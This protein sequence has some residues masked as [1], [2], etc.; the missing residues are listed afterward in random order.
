[1]SKYLYPVSVMWIAWSEKYRI[2]VIRDHRRNIIEPFLEYILAKARE[3]RD[4]RADPSAFHSGIENVVY[5]LVPLARFLATHRELKWDELNDEHLVSFRDWLKE[6][7]RK[8]PKSK[9][10]ESAKRTTNQRLRVIYEFLTWAQEDALLIEGVVGPSERFPVRSSLPLLRRSTHRSFR[11][12]KERFPKL[13]KDVGSSSRTSDR[14]Y[15]AT[16][17]D[18]AELREYFWEHCDEDA[19]SRNDLLM[20]VIDA[21]GFRRASANSL[22]TYVFSDAVIEKAIDEGLTHISVVPPEQKF[23]YNRAF[24]V[25]LNLAIA[26]NRYINTERRQLLAKAGCSETDKSIHRNRI[27]LSTSNATR[28]WPLTHGAVS[29]IFGKAFRAI[30]RKAGAAT[31]SFR[32]KFAEQRWAEEIEF[33]IRE[34]LSLAYEDIAM[35]VADDLGHESIVSQDAYH[36]VLSRIRKM[37]VEQQLRNQAAELNDEIAQLRSENAAVRALLGQLISGKSNVRNAY[38][39]K[40]IEQATELIRETSDA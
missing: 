8:K 13:Y 23:G 14:Q 2:A 39:R 25:S 9:N 22:T 32:R 18:F 37:S 34:G 7:T 33:R 29:K 36:R 3:M 20:R 16:E 38:D 19:A 4:T 26:I 11:S 31:H 15:W 21:T 6:E 10:E 28:G 12:A 1:M 40:L 35:A 27:F 24:P 17:T 5:A 30:G